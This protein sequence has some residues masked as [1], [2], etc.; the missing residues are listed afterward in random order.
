M[1]LKIYKLGE[2][3]LREKCAPVASEEINDEMRSLFEDMFETMVDANGVGLAAPQVGIA[4]RFFVVISDDDVKRVFINPQIVATSKELVPYD[5][6]CLSLPGFDEEIVRPAKVT[7]Q[8]LNEFGK[9]FT[10][11]TDGLLARIVQHE[12]DHLD[13]IV[14]IDRGD[15]EFAEKV[16]EKMRNRLEKARKKEEEKAKKAA[17]IAA[18]KAAKEASKAKK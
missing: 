7:I 2:D 15:K 18:K 12:N 16:T 8:A 3:V 5:E 13:G 4:K 6:G 9:P 1:I 17:S 14:Y 11:E 10:L